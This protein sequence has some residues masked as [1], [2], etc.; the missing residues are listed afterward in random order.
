MAIDTCASYEVIV[1]MFLVSSLL[2][3]FYTLRV[4]LVVFN[5]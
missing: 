5:C 1:I 2:L 4:D 3:L